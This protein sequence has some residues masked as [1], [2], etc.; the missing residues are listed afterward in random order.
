MQRFTKILS[1]LVLLVFVTAL[2]PV[3]FVQAQSSPEIDFSTTLEYLQNQ[4][5]ADGGFPGLSEGSDP[6]TTTRALIAMHAIA[7]DPAQFVSA[8]GLTP[9]DYLLAT[10]PGYISDD[11]QLLFPGNAGL[12][13]AALSLS[14]MAPEDLSALLL[15]T[16]QEDGSFSTEAAKDWNSGVATDLSQALA[17]LG[18][19]AHRDQIPTA[20]VDYLLAKQLEDGTWDNGFGSDPDTTAL[21]VVALLSTGQ[22][23]SDNAAIQKSF[24]YFRDTQLENAGWRPGWDTASLNVDTTG[25][26]TLALVSAGEDLAN[27]QVD[28]NS[29]R[30]ALQSAMQADG[31]I[32]EG[33]V[34]VY[35]TVEA[36]LGFAQQPL[37]EPLPPV[38]ATTSQAALVVALPD[39]STLLRCVEFSGETTSGY[40]LLKTSGLQL[41]TT[42]DPTKGNAICGI[43]GQGCERDNCFCGMPDYWS[44]WHI[45][46]SEWIYSSVGADTYQV[47]AGSVDGWSWGDQS[48]VLLSFDDVCGENAQLFLPA[49][50]TEDQQ[51]TSSVLLPLVEIPGEMQEVPADIVEG[52]PQPESENNAL[53]YLIFGVIVIGLIAVLL[54]VLREKRKA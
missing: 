52:T 24:Q 42:F 26:T 45:E 51:P 50:V 28:G 47:S 3:R 17:I 12:I 7:E 1:V 41:E 14:G 4:Q 33:F 35:S 15:D 53:Q 37:L 36:L 22:V 13:L 34:N 6:G 16:L 19:A 29:P 5:Q 21:V 44:Y 38:V 10:Y 23:D 18:L 54:L 2:V 43:E 30:D 11:N 31:S 32:G 27:W 8:D 25:W 40:E 46:N 9:R 39:G 20:A 49:V 48:P